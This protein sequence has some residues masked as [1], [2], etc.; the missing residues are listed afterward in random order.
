MQRAVL[1]R[2]LGG[3]VEILIAANPCFGLDFAAVAQIHAEIMAARNRGAAVLLV[4]EDL[5]E[6]LELADRVVVMFNGQFVYEARAS[7]ADLTEIG[8]H[9]AGTLIISADGVNDL[10]A[11]AAAGTG[12]G[13]ALERIRHRERRG[14]QLHLLAPLQPE[15]ILDAAV[16]ISGRARLHDEVLDALRHRSAGRRFRLGYVDNA[17]AERVDAVRRPD[18]RSGRASGLAQLG[19]QIA[20]DDCGGDEDQESDKLDRV[21]DVET[22]DRIVKEERRRERADE[23]RR[24][25]LREIPRAGSRPGPG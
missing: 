2:E 14:D 9:M 6:L 15:P 4:S 23:C 16:A 8:R 1:A 20:D 13:L 21:G 25:S 19:C 11:L 10:F 22:E 24:P 12:S 3:A 5:D 18:S 17:T 7:E